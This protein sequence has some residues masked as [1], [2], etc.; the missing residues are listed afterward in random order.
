M[1]LLLYCLQPVI[2]CFAVVLAALAVVVV[3]VFVVAALV[4]VFFGVQLGACIKRIIHRCVLITQP[5]ELC[6]AFDV[7]VTCVTCLQMAR[8]DAYEKMKPRKRVRY[9]DSSYR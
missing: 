7:I 5:C 1:E 8:T 9:R 6:I 3:L 2:C 4:V